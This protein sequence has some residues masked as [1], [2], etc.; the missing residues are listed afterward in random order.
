LK[1][2]LSKVLYIL[3]GTILD[4]KNNTITFCE[5][6]CQAIADNGNSDIMGP[7]KDIDTIIL[8]MSH[9]V[10]NVNDEYYTVNCNQINELPSIYIYSYYI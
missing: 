4:S 5:N 8:A 1:L 6:G 10:K 2:K 7:T 9:L 3:S